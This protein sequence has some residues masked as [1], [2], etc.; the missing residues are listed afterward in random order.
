MVEVFLY[1]YEYGTLKSVEIISRRGV[2][3]REI[4]GEDE[5]NLGMIYVYMEM[6]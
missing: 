4:N 3:E 1:M 5:P 6:S 2:G